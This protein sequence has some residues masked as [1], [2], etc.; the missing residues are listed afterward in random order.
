LHPQVAAVGPPP[1]LLRYAARVTAWAK[2]FACTLLLETPVYLFGLSRATEMARATRR[3]PSRTTLRFVGIAVLVNSITHPF[4]W[5]LTRAW[6]WPRF[7]A[8]EAGVWVAESLLLI[9]LVRP[10]SPLALAAVA[11]T[12]NALS[13]GVGLLL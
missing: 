6:S 7:A 2:A 9:A 8:V 10:A 12:A 3:A 1:P 13:A 5:A 11:F 4:A